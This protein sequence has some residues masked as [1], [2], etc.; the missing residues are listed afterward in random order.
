MRGDVDSNH[1]AK[2]LAKVNGP[3]ERTFCVSVHVFKAKASH[4]VIMEFD[5][6]QQKYSLE[7]NGLRHV[8]FCSRNTVETQSNI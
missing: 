2:S 5:C 7:R 4:V 3:S 8:E 6:G 1:R